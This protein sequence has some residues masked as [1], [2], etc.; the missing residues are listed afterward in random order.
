MD[1]RATSSPRKRW[2]EAK[3]LALSG[4]RPNGRWKRGTVDNPKSGINKTVRNAISKSGFVLD[5]APDLADA[6]G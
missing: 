5:H 3:T 4:Q 1:T 6:V 2:I